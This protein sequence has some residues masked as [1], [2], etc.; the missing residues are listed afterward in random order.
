MPTPPKVRISPS[1]TGYFH[2]GTG[3]TALLNWLFARQQ[4][5]TFL[6]RI[7]DTDEVRNRPQWTD[8]IYEAMGW[9]GL[10]W[11]E[12]YPQSRNADRH[13]EAAAKLLADGHAYW[14]QCRQ[15]DIQARN[16][17]AGIK[18]PGYDG[19][20]RDLGLEPGEGRAVRFRTPEEGTIVRDD[21]VY[22]RSE[23]DGAS[24]DDFVIVRANGAPLFVLANAIDD[25]DDGITHVIRGA[26]HLSNVEKQILL[27]RALGAE[28]P[29]WVHLPLLVNAQGKK[30]SKRRGDKV[31]V[32]MH[33]AEGVLA[34]AMRNYLGTLGWAPP[35]DE[36]IVPVETMVETFRLED[37]NRN[38]AQFDVKKLHAFNG[39]Y[40]RALPREEFL[41]RVVDWYRTT[42]LEPMA[43]VIQE[44][45]AT[46]PETLSMTDFL[47]HDAPPTD[48]ASWDK[49]MGKGPARRILEGAITAYE[50]LDDDAWVT[51]RLHAETEAVAA[52]VELSLGKAQAPIRV[53][54]TG[55][56]VGPPLFESLAVLG[57][58]RTLER[59]RRALAKLPPPA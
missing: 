18:T 22:G 54:V 2:V 38:P 55:R 17:A 23:I 51:E 11:D 57:R 19:H 39:H 48:A 29:V 52:A 26:D 56:S 30:L 10:D 16:A 27:R 45:G 49:A 47:L 6:L 59:L 36:E 53:A 58:D 35:G 46:W 12:T 20:C 44:R 28:E 4:G 24:F 40:L 32:E 15:E 43:E 25:L 5:G 13:R 8:G 14:C 9:L 41:D 34:E 50:A 7:E 42:I 37:V 31:S 1:P 21:V 3:R 33:R